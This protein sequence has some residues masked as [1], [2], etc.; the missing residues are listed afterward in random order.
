MTKLSDAQRVILAAAAK[1]EDLTIILPPRLRGG[2]ADKA[3]AALEKRGF[4][5]AASNAPGLDRRADI[6]GATGYAA[7]TAGLAAIGI[8]VAP[9]ALG[10]T[11]ASGA[12]RVD[13][14]ASRAA[15]TASE[16][17]AETPRRHARTAGALPSPSTRGA[18]AQVPSPASASR[19]AS[20]LPPIAGA[21]LR[22]GTKLATLVGLL[23]RREGASL[24][25]MTRATAWLPHTVR[26][27]LTGLKK[28]GFTVTRSA[29]EDGAPARYRIAG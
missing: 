11:A 29:G 7:T 16:P 1:R 19:A 5:V 6:A 21:A 26:A 27:T 2:A 4:V 12:S 13:G 25:E 22:P 9:A 24:H 10:A 18:A 17:G 15:T 28:R 3:L 14:R 8:E 23:G 20:D